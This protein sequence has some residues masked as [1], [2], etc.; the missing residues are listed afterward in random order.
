MRTID[1]RKN[2]LAVGEREKLGKVHTKE[3][4]KRFIVNI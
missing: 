4:G 3:N 1:A 2:N